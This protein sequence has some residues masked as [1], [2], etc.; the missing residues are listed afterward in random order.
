MIEE[1]NQEITKYEDKL[2]FLRRTKEGFAEKTSP[3]M[4]HIRKESL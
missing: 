2:D 1:L 4:N 3:I